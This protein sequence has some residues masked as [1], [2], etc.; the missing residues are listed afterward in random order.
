M[1]SQVDFAQSSSRTGVAFIR[2]TVAAAAS[3]VFFRVSQICW[4]VSST[5]SCNKM[6]L[7]VGVA[8]LSKRCFARLKSFTRA[9]SSPSAGKTPQRNNRHHCF[10]QAVDPNHI[11]NQTPACPSP[12]SPPMES[13]AG[14]DCSSRWTPNSLQHRCAYDFVVVTQTSDYK[15]Y[16]TGPLPVERP[17]LRPR[18][19]YSILVKKCPGL[20]EVLGS[21][22]GVR[23]SKFLCISFHNYEC[24]T[25][26]TAPRH[27]E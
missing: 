3:F 24:P 10:K 4:A 6:S 22:A 14:N 9:L 7:D 20:V 2:N 19:A 27:G 21:R 25:L 12:F 23:R 18:L 8:E 13:T 16:I 11:V 15:P 1:S 5:A 17:A 26:F